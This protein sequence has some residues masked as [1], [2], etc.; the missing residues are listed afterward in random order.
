MADNKIISVAWK[1]PAMKASS[2]L[3]FHPGCWQKAEKE[4]K[5]PI[6]DIRE[7]EI[8]DPGK[9]TVCDYCE[10]SF[11]YKPS[12]LFHRGVVY[13]I[14]VKCT[15]ALCSDGKQRTAQITSQHEL[16]AFS[17]SARVVVQGKGVSGFISWDRDKGVHTFTAYTNRKNGHLLNGKE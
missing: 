17:L 9:H 16:D 3:Y 4:T 5:L 13:Q 14:T 8:K 1:S 2:F 12:E 15:N 11:I 7:I 6:T 10:K